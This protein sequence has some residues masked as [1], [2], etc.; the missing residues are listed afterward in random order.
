M[1]GDPGNVDVK[2][3]DAE[4]TQARVS[5]CK[6]TNCKYDNNKYKL[7]CTK[8]KRLLHY[9]CTDDPFQPTNFSYS[10]QRITENSYAV[11]ELKYLHAYMPYL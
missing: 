6:P 7:E 8:C 1:D 10:L 4:S 9:G 3:K 11:N 5:Q 2:L